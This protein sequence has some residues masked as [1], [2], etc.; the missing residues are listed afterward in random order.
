MLYTNIMCLVHKLRNFIPVD[1]EGDGDGILVMA[2]VGGGGGLGY[3]VGVIGDLMAITPHILDI[4]NNVKTVRGV[5]LMLVVL[6]LLVNN[7]LRGKQKKIK[8]GLALVG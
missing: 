5:L 6:A 8:N 3:I 7:S 2:H 4:G 1:G